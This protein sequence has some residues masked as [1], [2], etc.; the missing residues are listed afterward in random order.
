MTAQLSRHMS[1]MSRSTKPGAGVSAAVATLSTATC[2]PSGVKR[3]AFVFVPPL[4]NP[5]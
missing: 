3:A 1:S 2:V 4:S 5:R